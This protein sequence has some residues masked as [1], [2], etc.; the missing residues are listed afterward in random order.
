MDLAAELRAER[1]RRDLN[2][3]DA[4]AL[5]G[6]TARALRNWEADRNLTR[7]MAASEIVTIAT[8]LRVAPSVV[9]AALIG[10]DDAPTEHA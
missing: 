6:I 8:F 5:M 1:A 7:K 9:I 4:A 3:N 2:Q 10:P